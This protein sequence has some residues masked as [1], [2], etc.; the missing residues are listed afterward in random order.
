MIF[1]QIAELVLHEKNSITIMFKL[2][3]GKI[4]LPLMVH[5]I[6]PNLKRAISTCRFK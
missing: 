3:S 2:F 5:L 1:P 6:L 4:A